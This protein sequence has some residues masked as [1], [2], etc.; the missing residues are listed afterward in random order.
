MWNERRAVKDQM[1][2]MGTVES[3]ILVTEWH[4]RASHMPSE[5]DYQNT[6]LSLPDEAQYLSLNKGFLLFSS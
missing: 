3:M 1:R 4:P 6:H 5:N 2:Y